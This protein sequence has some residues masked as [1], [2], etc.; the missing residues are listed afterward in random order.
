MFDPDYNY[1]YIKKLNNSDEQKCKG[2]SG[3]YYHISYILS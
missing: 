2:G 1:G 3:V